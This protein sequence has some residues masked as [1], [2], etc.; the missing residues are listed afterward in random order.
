[1][2][3]LQGGGGGGGSSRVVVVVAYFPLVSH[4]YTVGGA[5]ISPVLLPRSI[6]TTAV[7]SIV[8]DAVHDTAALDLLFVFSSLDYG[9]HIEGV[10]PVARSMFVRLPHM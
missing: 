1:M 2:R 10:T 3:S 8:L 4:V 7:A 6:S 9:A 5:C